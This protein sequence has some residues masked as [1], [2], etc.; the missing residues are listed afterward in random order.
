M[1]TDQDTVEKLAEKPAEKTIEAKNDSIRQEYAFASDVK[2]K[3]CKYCRVMI[4]KNAKI[5]PNCKMTLKSHMFIKT[6]AAVLVFAVIVAGGYC[7]FTYRELQPDPEAVALETQDE[8]QAPIVS[9]N[10]VETTEAAAGAKVVE[11]TEV[12]APAVTVESPQF[13]PVVESVGTEKSASNEAEQ[14]EETKSAAESDNVKDKDVTEEGESTED[15]EKP[16]DK[17]DPEDRNAVDDE[18]T[19]EDEETED[20]VSTTVLKAIDENE[21]AFRADCVQRKYKSLLR[22]EEYLETSVVVMGAEVVCQVDGGLFDENVYYLCREKENGNN[23]YY[24]IRDDRNEDETLILEGDIITVYGQL[25]GT[26]KIPANL[27]ET[28]PTVPAISMLTYDLLGE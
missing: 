9:V 21:A 12:V 22:D 19:V 7:I 5:C 16:D 18:N 28:R 2:L 15:K 1:R 27:I 17:V 10:T 23:C 20:D 3:E 4:P 8:T 11:P 24:I 14:K 13:V 26:C 6:L 25:F